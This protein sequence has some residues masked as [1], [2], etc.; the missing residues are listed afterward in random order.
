MPCELSTG[1]VASQQ[2]QQV[3]ETH[4][5]STRSQQE[6]NR[7][8][9]VFISLLENKHLVSE[10]TT[11]CRRVSARLDVQT[12]AISS[13]LV[14][15]AVCL[16]TSCQPVSSSLLGPTVALA[17]KANLVELLA[18]DCWPSDNSSQDEAESGV[19]SAEFAR[20]WDFPRLGGALVFSVTESR[21][22]KPF[23]ETGELTI[24]TVV[25]EL[26]RAA[27]ITTT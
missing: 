5:L 24:C 10:S 27:S 9:A 2:Q 6:K 7:K 21:R 1:C 16:S 15:I 11:A 18:A 3:T 20:R 26:F 19:Y 23:W 14:L 25:G 8:R 13:E 12:W 4:R 17:A 22:W